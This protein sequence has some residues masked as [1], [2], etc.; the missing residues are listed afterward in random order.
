MAG[1]LF[2]ENPKAQPGR[3]FVVD[4]SGARKLLGTIYLPQGTFRVEGANN[5]VGAASAYTVIVADQIDIKSATLVINADYGATDVP[6][7]DGLG[8]KS[9]QVRLLN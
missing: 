5:I 4:T 1:I 6:V 8:P 9:N 3:Q 2:F 7:P